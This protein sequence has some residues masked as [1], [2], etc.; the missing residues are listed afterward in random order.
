MQRNKHQGLGVRVFDY[1][2]QGVK[3]HQ[4]KNHILIAIMDFDYALWGDKTNNNLVKNLFFIDQAEI[5]TVELSRFNKNLEEL[6]SEL[7]YWLYLFKNISQLKEIPEKFIGTPFQKVIEMSRI[8]AL[9]Q[10]EKADWIRELEE[11]EVLKDIRKREVEEIVGEASIISYNEGVEHGQELGIKK[12][13][14]EG[15]EERR[16]L[17]QKIIAQLRAEGFSDQKIMSML[18][19]DP[20][21]L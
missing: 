21:D 1:I 3:E 20:E 4:D 2:I 14:E 10:Q 12:G 11:D 16:K 13:R 6:E 5:I 8:K 17:L 15:R 19:I 18:N 7:D 9:P